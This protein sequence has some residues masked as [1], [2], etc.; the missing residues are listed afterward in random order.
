M[1]RRRAMRV[2]RAPWWCRAHFEGPWMVAQPLREQ[3]V[4]QCHMEHKA[5]ASRPAPEETASLRL[6]RLAAP[7]AGRLLAWAMPAVASDAAPATL[8]GSWLALRFI[9]AS[10]V[11]CFAAPNAARAA[12]SSPSLP[13]RSLHTSASF[14]WCGGRRVLPAQRQHQEQRQKLF[15]K[16]RSEAG[17]SLGRI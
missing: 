17:P 9:N 14:S 12:P 7:P 1:G 2:V 3:H 4:A 10:R 15:G 8:A 11:P 16:R 6:A 5:A 13:D